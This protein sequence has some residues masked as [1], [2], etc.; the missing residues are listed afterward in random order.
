MPEGR[1]MAPRT[2]QSLI[3]KVL[4]GGRPLP[5]DNEGLP[6]SEEKVS[7]FPKLELRLPD[8]TTFIL[9]S[10]F[11]DRASR[12]IQ[13]SMLDLVRC[14]ILLHRGTSVRM[15]TGIRCYVGRGPNYPVNVQSPHNSDYLSELPPTVDWNNLKLMT[16]KYSSNTWFT[17]PVKVLIYSY[18]YGVLLIRIMKLTRQLTENLEH[19]TVVEFGR[20]G[21][22]MNVRL[23]EILT[24][25]HK[26]LP[27]DSLRPIEGNVLK[28]VEHITKSVEARTK[29][30]ITIEEQKELLRRAE[31]D[32]KII[33][34]MQFFDYGYISPLC[35]ALFATQPSYGK[36]TRISWKSGIVTRVEVQRTNDEQEFTFDEFDK[37][38]EYRRRIIENAYHNANFKAWVKEMNARYT[39]LR[40]G[41][42]K[43]IPKYEEKKVTDAMDAFN[44]IILDAFHRMGMITDLVQNRINAFKNVVRYESKD[45]AEIV[46][47]FNYIGGR[48]D[49]A[50]GL[51]AK[52]IKGTEPNVLDNSFAQ[53]FLDWIANKYQ[54]HARTPFK[55]V[56]MALENY[57]AHLPDFIANDRAFRM[58][59]ATTDPL[60]MRDDETFLDVRGKYEDSERQAKK[61]VGEVLR[62]MKTVFIFP[63]GVF[64]GEFSNS[65]TSSS[66]SARVKVEIEVVNDVDPNI[67][68]SYAPNFKGEF[69]VYDVFNHIVG[70]IDESLLLSKE[71][72]KFKN[73]ITTIAGQHEALL[74]RVRRNSSEFMQKE[75]E[76]LDGMIRSIPINCDVYL[77][78]NDQFLN[79]ID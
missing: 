64:A 23:K 67:L 36:R 9:N 62:T 60:K 14:F 19:E 26:N 1:S 55:Y 25:T 44:N 8:S 43:L 22:D 54:E 53:K 56:I 27:D 32:D 37:N 34:L 48:N 66:T 59:E 21:M 49:H 10:N 7:I 79:T 74:T 77:F 11:L 24:S 75:F 70:E 76:T 50:L 12:C 15:D 35:S 41:T 33:Q 4:V 16:I 61:L 30:S 52:L 71:K 65:S 40:E 18:V 51:V 3:G 20:F 5:I 28:I 46:S 2:A 38:F 72:E 63:V 17:D 31:D 57:L 78:R 13:S 39:A 6:L 45:Y 47:V 68:R 69:R 29:S 73:D 42:F 58:K